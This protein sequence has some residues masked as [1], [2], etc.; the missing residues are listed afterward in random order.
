MPLLSWALSY[1]RPY[2]R[3]VVAVA[4]LTLLQVGL[5]ALEPWPLKLVIDYVLGHHPLP[6]PLDGVAW[7]T[8]A[9]TFELLAIFVSFG[10]LLQLTHQV[11]AAFG[12]RLQSET[13]QRMVYDLRYRL[14]DHL[15]SLSLQHYISTS[16][17]DAVYRVDVDAYSIENLA[18]SGILPI[19]SAAMTLTVMFAVLAR[20]DLQV[21]LLSL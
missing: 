9:G 10:A 5:G 8:S 6:A 16:T 7:L 3:R 4:A 1:V 21:A 14:L 20:L 17:G 19:V 18:M 15:Q 11:A 12:V 13:G 2:W